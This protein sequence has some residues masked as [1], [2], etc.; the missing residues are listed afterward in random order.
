MSYTNTSYVK[1]G[2]SLAMADVSIH[3][4]PEGYK[5]NFKEQGIVI[6]KREM[7]KVKRAGA[8][9]NTKSKKKN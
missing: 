2:K 9:E 3:V 6:P 1:K 8:N 7:P 4:L 5:F